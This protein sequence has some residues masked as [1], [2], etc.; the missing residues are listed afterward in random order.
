MHQG[1]PSPIMANGQELESVENFA[2]LGSPINRGLTIEQELQTRIG[3]AASSFSR[4]RGRAWQN[5]FLT[6]RTK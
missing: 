2:Y 3:R 1:D 4:L 5:K 6:I